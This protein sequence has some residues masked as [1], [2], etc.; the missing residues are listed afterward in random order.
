MVEKITGYEFSSRFRKDYR[1][2]SNL[3]AGNPWPPVRFLARDW[4]PNAMATW[5]V[6]LGLVVVGGLL[7]HFARTRLRTLAQRDVPADASTAA[8]AG[9]ATER[10][11]G[12]A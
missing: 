5:G 7:G 9:E 3:Q 2:L 11:G 8:S 1:A 10:A 12:P 6:P 4:A